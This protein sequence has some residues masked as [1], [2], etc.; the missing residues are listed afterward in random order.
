[1]IKVL[2]ATRVPGVDVL[3][4]IQTHRRHVVE[5]MQEWTRVKRDAAAQDVNLA[6]VV[7]AELY[8]LDAVIRWLDAAQSRLRRSALGAEPPVRSDGPAQ[9]GGTSAAA[10]ESTSATGARR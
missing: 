5:L 6:L 7:D 8:R 10:P 2:V 1:V 9:V 4:V 3:D